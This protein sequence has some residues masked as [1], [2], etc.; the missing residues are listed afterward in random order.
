MLILDKDKSSIKETR[1]VSHLLNENLDAVIPIFVEPLKILEVMENKD[2]YLKF[3]I[4]SKPKPDIE[5]ELNGK[6][7]TLD[8]LETRFESITEDSYLLT[9]KIS[10]V[11]E[12]DKGEYKIIARNERGDAQTSF[13]LIVTKEKEKDV[14][15]KFIKTFDNQ[16]VIEDQD[17]LLRIKILGTP[18]PTV[19]WFR[20]GKKLK[21]SKR[22]K[23]N[24]IEEDV[25]ELIIEK[26]LFDKDTGVYKVVIEN[27]AG[28]CS[29]SATVDI[30]KSKLTFVEK[31]V[32][33]DVK[34]R[35]EALFVVKISD[36]NAKVTW[37]KDGLE[38]EENEKYTFIEEG[39]YRKLLIKDCDVSDEGEYTCQLED[40]EE[41]LADL[42]VIELPP[43][44]T[45]MLQDVKVMK[46]Q[47]AQFTIELTK[48]DALDGTKMMKRFLLTIEFG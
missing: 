18:K 36:S 10:N 30:I 13:D 14:Q 20:N 28:V 29:H 12:V 32:E 21:E 4:L 26:C 5:L 48:G 23:Q 27:K 19:T 37:L 3:K 39:Y 42:I 35:E 31:L 40:V 24:V 17:L 1:R 9:I 47:T 33:L 34:E 6:K 22:I 2:V 16:T 44:I 38:I 41:C 8:Q 7:I 46:G 11:Q 45:T 15:P 43:E 25:Y